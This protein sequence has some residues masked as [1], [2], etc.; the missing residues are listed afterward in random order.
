MTAAADDIDD[1]A[2]GWF[3]R[4]RAGDMDPADAAALEAWLEADPAHRA[5]LD[6]LSRAWGRAE[7]ARDDPEILAWRERAKRRRA[8]WPVPARAVAAALLVAAVLG[9]AGWQLGRMGL[10]PWSGRFYD[11][12]FQTDLGQRATFTLRDGSKVTLN[13]DSRLRTVASQGR[14]LLYLDRGQAFFQVAK[15][16]SRPFVVKAGGRTVTAIGT[17][18][19]VRVEPNRFEVTLVEG[20]VRVET[21]ALKPVARPPGE[22]APPE[23]VHQTTELTPGAQLVASAAADWSVTQTD[24]ARETS[25]LNGRLMFENEPLGAVAA[26]FGR[27]SD[28]RIVFDDPGLAATPVTGTF[29]SGDVAGF[30]RALEKYR[31]ARVAG[32]SDEVIRLAA[33]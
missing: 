19:D 14:R 16:A 6:A 31:L 11:Q 30:S 17:A 32:E 9:G 33:W 27:Y 4:R 15:D 25:W 22:P 24:T 20:R 5:A 13:T 18:F 10:L 3:A 29:R 2:A 1:V 12:E 8:P 28:R 21:P 7:A 26:E 23:P